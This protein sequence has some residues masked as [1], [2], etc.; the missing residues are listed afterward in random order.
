MIMIDLKWSIVLIIAALLIT[1][2]TNESVTP[3]A[4]EPS[5][6]ETTNTDTQIKY[7]KDMMDTDDILYYGEID[8]PGSPVLYSE[9]SSAISTLEDNTYIIRD[10]K[11]S[12]LSKYDGYTITTDSLPW[13]YKLD[14][15]FKKNGV[16]S[17]NARW[18][19]DH[20]INAA[21]SLEDL[22][23]NLENDTSLTSCVTIIDPK[24]DDLDFTDSSL[25]LLGVDYEDSY[26]KV[27]I[28]DQNIKPVKD[29]NFRNV[30]YEWF[31]EY[32]II[33]DSD[34]DAKVIISLIPV[35]DGTIIDVWVDQVS[36]DQKDIKNC[37]EAGKDEYPYL[38]SMDDPKMS[39]TATY[40]SDVKIEGR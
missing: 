37:N 26:L 8:M 10:V 40:H 33:Y 34:M 32:E 17:T 39:F 38:C 16:D 2:C 35:D 14:R 24:I 15:L 36:L 18:E 20:M 29:R 25:S 13:R 31:R 5:L 22:L 21:L 12:S 19:L 7:I 6:S 11:T 28:E 9:Q 23:P 30:A 4:D 1:G 3:N 27:V